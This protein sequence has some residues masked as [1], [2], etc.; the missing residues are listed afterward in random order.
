[1][2]EWTSYRASGSWPFE[3]ECLPL[4]VRRG[5]G[6]RNRSLPVDRRQRARRRRRRVRQGASR[7]DRR[8]RL[9]GNS[10][11][12]LR[13]D[14]RIVRR[15]N[16][17]HLPWRKRRHGH[18]PALTGATGALA[19]TRA[20]AATHAGAVAAASPRRSAKTVVPG[21][22]AGLG[23]VVVNRPEAV[24]R[25]RA[26]RCRRRRH[27]RRGSRDR[28]RGSRLLEAG[29]G[30]RPGSDG[31]LRGA[32]GWSPLRLRSSGGRSRPRIAD[33]GRRTGG[34]VGVLGGAERRRRIVL[35]PAVLAA[36]AA[37][38]G[39]PCPDQ[40]NESNHGRL[41]HRIPFPR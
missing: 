31:G 33:H 22:R 30:R 10:R 1:M 14:A 3:S 8:Q 12:R 17:R 18:A 24:D 5:R 27:V 16:R 34:V 35:V 4:K 19:F 40:A 29:R 25:G 21:Q 37:G 20:R 41:A 15:R 36:L 32:D 38:Q 2:R 28:T 7:S 26:R 6:R 13:G 23:A 11:S 9:P 39:H